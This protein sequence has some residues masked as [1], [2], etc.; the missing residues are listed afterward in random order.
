MPTGLANW[1]RVSLSYNPL[2]RI[3]IRIAH[4]LHISPRI[5]SF[6]SLT[7][8]VIFPTPQLVGYLSL[9][10]YL[11]TTTCGY[12]TYG[13]SLGLELPMIT[14]LTTVE[15]ALDTTGVLASWNQQASVQPVGNFTL[16]PSTTACH[17]ARASRS[18]AVLTVCS[19][20]CFS[21]CPPYGTQ[22]NV[23]FMSRGGNWQGVSCI[24]SSYPQS[25]LPASYLTLRVG[26]C[27]L[28]LTGLTQFN[29]SYGRLTGTVPFEARLESRE[30]QCGWIRRGR[31]LQYVEIC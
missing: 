31:R 26:G 29:A 7:P 10:V 13:T 27:N 8:A 16:T 6:S 12:N 25:A 18:L 11:T 21:Q 3:A 20:V 14:T 4:L 15:A 1:Y 24:E 28:A 30:I 23:G 5:V 9:G 17:D 19:R 22:P 2:V